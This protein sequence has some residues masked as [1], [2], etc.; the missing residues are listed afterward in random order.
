[1]F[2]NLIWDYFVK[3]EGG[4]KPNAKWTSR[5]THEPTTSK[6]TSSFKTALCDHFELVTT[7][8]VTSVL[9]I[10]VFQTMILPSELLCIE[11]LAKA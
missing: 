4:I 5:Q 1:M 2:V 10:F 8:M 6:L 11:W 3:A 9:E 7:V